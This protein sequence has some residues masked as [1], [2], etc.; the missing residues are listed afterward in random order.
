[1]LQGKATDLSNVKQNGPYPRTAIGQISPTKYVVVV[2]DGK[3][4][5]YS[6]GFTPTELQNIFIEKGCK[7]AYNLDGGGSTSLYFNGRLINEPSDG[8]ERPVADILYFK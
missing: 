3:R 8:E 7:Y 5:Y 1:M 2:A 6:V 4:F